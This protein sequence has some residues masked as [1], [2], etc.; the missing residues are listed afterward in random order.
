MNTLQSDRAPH[1]KIRHQ[2][3]REAAE[4]GGGQPE[5]GPQLEQRRREPGVR[6]PQQSLP[7]ERQHRRLPH[8]QR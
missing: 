7:E 1:D 3:D 5:E 6:E 4:E 8:P 2:D